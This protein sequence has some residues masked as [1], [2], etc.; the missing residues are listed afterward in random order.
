LEPFVPETGTLVFFCL[1]GEYFVDDFRLHAREEGL[2]EH[3]RRRGSEPE[4]VYEDGFEEDRGTF[5]FWGAPGSI[6]CSS[7]AR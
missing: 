5:R 1:H 6:F 4:I 2:Q 3:D 7:R